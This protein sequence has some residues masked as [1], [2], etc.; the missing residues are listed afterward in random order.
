MEDKRKGAVKTAI[1]C[2]LKQKHSSFLKYSAASVGATL[3][4]ACP[5]IVSS[6]LFLIYCGEYDGLY[7]QKG[8]A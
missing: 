7:T 2:L 8:T 6:V 5:T 3:G 1:I 4:I